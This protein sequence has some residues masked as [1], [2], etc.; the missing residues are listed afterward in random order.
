M[1]QF[2]DIYNQA[3]YP[4]VILMDIEE[5]TIDLITHAKDLSPSMVFNGTSTLS[6]DIT[7][8][9]ENPT[10]E[11]YD[12]IVLKNRVLLEERDTVFVI[13]GCSETVE[14][15]TKTK[16]VECI[17]LETE[18]FNK[19]V[20]IQKGTYQF[21]DVL[22]PNESILGTVMKQIPEWK[23]GYVTTE[24]AL[25]K[26][27]FDDNTTIAHSFLMGEV[28]DKF[29]CIFKF[30]TK[31]KIVN[32]YTYDDAGHDTDIVA[33]MTDVVQDVT[34]TPDNTKFMTAI[35][36]VGGNGLSISTVNPLGGNITYDYSGV[37]DRMSESLRNKVTLWDNKVQS[38]Q[39]EY[40]NLLTTLN[41]KNA[42]MQ[43]LKTALK[44]I[45]TNIA[46]KWEAM[47]LHVDNGTTGTS[48]YQQ[49][50]SEHKQLIT[51]EIAKKKEIE[52]KQ[53][54][55]DTVFNQLKAI[56]NDLQL[57]N[58]FTPD[59]IVKLTRYTYVS[60]VVDEMYIQ[61]S[62]MTNK[63]I[64]DMAQ[65]LYD[66]HKKILAKQ[67]GELIAIDVTMDNFIFDKDRYYYTQNLVLGNNITVE[68][69]GDK[70]A[71]ARLLVCEWNYDDPKSM[72]I[73]VADGLKPVGNKY[74][75]AEKV[76]K[77]QNI[78]NTIKADMSGWKEASSNNTYLNTL[79]NEGL[80]ANLTAIKSNENAEFKVDGTGAV[81]RKYNPTTETYSPE[82]IWIAHN[83][84]VITDN[85]FETI[86]LAIGKLLRPDGTTW[87]YGISTNIL[88]GKILMGQKCIIQ[89]EDTMVTIDG[90]GIKVENGHIFIK[91]KNGQAYIDGEKISLGGTVGLS[92]NKSLPVGNNVMIFAGASTYE[93]RDNALFRVYDDG[94]VVMQNADVTGDI[95]ATSIDLQGDLTT[96]DGG[97][98][99]EGTGDAPLFWG[100][101]SH[102]N[103][104]N[105]NF[106]VS[107][108]GKLVTKDIDAKGKIECT[109]LY[110]NG[111]RI[112][113]IRNGKIG[114]E[115]V[116]NLEAMNINATFM[117]SVSSWS[118]NIFTEELQTNFDDWIFGGNDKQAV[119]YIYINKEKQQMIT[120]NVSLTEYDF[121]V[122][123][124]QNV[125]TLFACGEEKNR[126]FTF[127]NMIET[128]ITFT[129]STSYEFGTVLKS[130]NQYKVI[131]DY[132][133]AN[134]YTSWN[135]LVPPIAEICTVDD[136]RVKI[137]KTIGEPLIKWEQKFDDIT[138]TNGTTVKA[139][140]QTWGE[141]S[142][143][144]RGKF[145]YYK[146]QEGQYFI[147]FNENNNDF[148][149]F[150]LNGVTCD[151]EKWNP[152]LKQWESIGSNWAGGTG[153]IIAHKDKTSLVAADMKGTNALHV[154]Y[155]STGNKIVGANS[156]L[157]TSGLSLLGWES[158]DKIPTIVPLPPAYVWHE[159]FNDQGMFPT[160]KD[161]YIY[162]PTSKRT[163]YGLT[164][165]IGQ[166]QR[167]VFNGL[168]I[169]KSKL[170]YQVFSY[171]ILSSDR[172]HVIMPQIYVDSGNLWG[173]VD[174]GSV[175]LDLFKVP[176]AQLQENIDLEIDIRMNKT[177]HKISSTTMLNGTKY[178][179]EP[180]SITSGYDSS[181]LWNG[182][183]IYLGDGVC[184][185]VV[186][187]AKP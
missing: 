98:C 158:V 114:A 78:D 175:R 149:G 137:K 81:M 148:T 3:E 94:R 95:T 177:T 92:T 153:V 130:N 60:S 32:A 141:G 45:E 52:T 138:L 174:Y 23:V 54:E 41:N 121:L 29:Q 69:G 88:V 165:T 87:D 122:V 36:V 6:F 145:D 152:L 170:A 147:Q 119:N 4:R 17:S 155:S 182:F 31:N 27:G 129:P 156:T 171:A 51:Q 120:R 75:V 99:N 90:D 67:S 151:M 43:I 25:V 56:N 20:T 113:A 63:E 103:R 82:Q 28:E 124:G 96:P 179:G 13:I 47:S 180:K 77:K 142:G 61:T 167:L 157:Y 70:F 19:P 91:D 105:A 144:G 106:K 48:A 128:A 50:A 34:K 12:D 79:Q 108:N 84:I 131:T 15:D 109:E 10:I 111:E 66:K 57:V 64:Q 71:T 134:T 55:I 116:E 42:E 164:I 68:L 11:Y 107:H 14:G 5:N 86:K 162:G 181:S 146:G 21:W 163:A 139:P 93:L 16:N 132:N 166:I 126:F 72:S 8:N 62:E 150:R 76:I 80:N 89:S 83:Q 33:R 100:G 160:A 127:E 38:R 173:L 185:D 22:K 125:Y 39:Q 140:K 74:E 24:L 136:F 85:A 59:E 118:K 161:S 104:H 44:E 178:V 168:K 73:Q 102:S 30:D 37:L 135:D 97:I 35:E 112:N 133:M 9:V 101:T 58:N 184:L 110:L 176:L 159:H 26:Y 186:G 172:G 1:K 53:A 123:N 49:L 183:D 169:T 2:F 7:D 187:I 115:F 154:G 40:A 143:G 65:K 46:V 117:K 18:D